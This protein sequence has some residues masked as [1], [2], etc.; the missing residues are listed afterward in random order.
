MVIIRMLVILIILISISINIIIN[1]H[2]FLVVTSLGVV[3]EEKS[4]LHDIVSNRCV[5]YD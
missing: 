2:C 5:T 3:G 1:D 4:F